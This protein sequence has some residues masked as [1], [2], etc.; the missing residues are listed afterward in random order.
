MTSNSCNFP[1]PV[2]FIYNV[3]NEANESVDL[4]N[5]Y[6]E[7]KKGLNNLCNTLS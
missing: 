3:P 4:I 1:I 2:F 7:I 6:V 5:A